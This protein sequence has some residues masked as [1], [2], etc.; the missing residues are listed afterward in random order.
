MKITAR[1]KLLGAY[2]KGLDGGDWVLLTWLASQF[3]AI[4]TVFWV[5]VWCQ[6]VLGIVVA[7]IHMAEVAKESHE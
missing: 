4:P 6:F 3:V 1:E 2:S 5:V 7:A